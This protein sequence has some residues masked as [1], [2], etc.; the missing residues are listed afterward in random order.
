MS[1]KINDVM[2]RGDWAKIGILVV[3]SATLWTWVWM[4]YQKP[5][6]PEGYEDYYLGSDTYQ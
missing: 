6:F 4:E 2:T 3:I 1:I 5:I